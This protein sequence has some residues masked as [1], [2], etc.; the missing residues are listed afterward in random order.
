MTA[1]QS[2]FDGGVCIVEMLTAP[3]ESIWSGLLGK[4]ESSPLV[5][6][7]QGNYQVSVDANGVMTMSTDATL[8]SSWG[9]AARVYPQYDTSTLGTQ[10]SSISGTDNHWGGFCLDD[11]GDPP[12][13]SAHCVALTFDATTKVAT[14]ANIAF[15]AHAPAGSGAFVGVLVT[16]GT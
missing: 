3:G 2:M 1:W 10:I 4:N 16:E 11:L 15:S 6:N 13:T 7:S 12:T 14:P 5:N 8:G 9:G